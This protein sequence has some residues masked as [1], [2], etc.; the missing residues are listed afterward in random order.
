MT[1]QLEEMSFRTHDVLFV[2][3]EIITVLLHP[4]LPFRICDVRFYAH[5]EVRMPRENSQISL[6]LKEIIDSQDLRNCSLIHF[7]SL[8]C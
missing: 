8:P 1:Q 6:W 2:Y 4:S 3:F 7:K 5:S